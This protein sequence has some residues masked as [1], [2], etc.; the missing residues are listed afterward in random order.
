MVLDEPTAD[1]DNETGRRLM[2]AVHEHADAGG[3]GL[4]LIT[5]R[6][7]G[8]ERMDG[9]LVLSEGR[10]VERGTHEALMSAEGAYRRM[11]EV[12]EGMLAGR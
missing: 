6:L 8:M 7:V 9:I 2:E 4:L 12:Q 5:H 1:L 11:V 10:I 3:L